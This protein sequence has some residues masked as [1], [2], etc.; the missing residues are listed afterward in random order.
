[1]HRLSKFF[2]PSVYRILPSRSHIITGNLSRNVV[3]LQFPMSHVDRASSSSQLSKPLISGPQFKPTNLSASAAHL[4]PNTAGLKLNLPFERDFL[5]KPEGLQPTQFGG[6]SSMRLSFRI[7]HA[8]A[9][10]AYSGH[11]SIGVA[12]SS[13]CTNGRP[14][15]TGFNPSTL[16]S[17]ASTV[18]PPRMHIVPICS[19]PA[20]LFATP[21]TSLKDKL[22][23][24]QRSNEPRSTNELIVKLP[25]VLSV[26][27]TSNI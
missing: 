7:S 9:S 15:S 19:I 18:I 4:L 1:M 8:V 20:P 26:L 24:Q 10:F 6:Q 13:L 22:G 2:S 23:L 16:S 17:L 25:V 12:T 5:K 14:P 21:L 11:F 3:V 27:T